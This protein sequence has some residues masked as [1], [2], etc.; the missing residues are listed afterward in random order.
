MNGFVGIVNN[1]GIEYGDKEFD[2][3]VVISW[4]VYYQLDR[5]YIA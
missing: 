1:V 3:W 4:N 2:R 5:K